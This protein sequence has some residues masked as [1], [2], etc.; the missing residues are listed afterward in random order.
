M[1]SQES[2][3][4]SQADR[5]ENGKQVPPCLTSGYMSHIHH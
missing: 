3:L 1:G 5:E 4:S 2:L